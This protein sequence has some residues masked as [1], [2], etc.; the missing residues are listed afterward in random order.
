M[1]T[2]RNRRAFTLRFANQE[3]HQLLELVSARLGVSMNELAE[4]MIE[5]E[6]G[7]ASFALQ[8]DLTHTLS[9]LAAYHGDPAED[10]ARVAHAEVEYADPI[11]ARLRTSDN[12]PL[13]I[14]NVFAAAARTG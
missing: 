12:D 11:R 8:E 4:K 1:V 5:N 6:L 13:G 7:I 14:A 3:T 2:Q 10:V 9:L